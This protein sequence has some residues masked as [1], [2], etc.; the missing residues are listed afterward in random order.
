MTIIRF[1]MV[2]ME[3]E[4]EMDVE[5]VMKMKVEVVRAQLKMLPYFNQHIMFQ[6]IGRHHHH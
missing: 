2:E 5:V 6:N 3:V 4:V 1:K